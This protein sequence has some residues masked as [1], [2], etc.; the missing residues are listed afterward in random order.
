VK[1]ET[2]LICGIAIT[3]LA[4]VVILIWGFISMR[5]PRQ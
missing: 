4:T 1:L 3:E 5:E 2:F